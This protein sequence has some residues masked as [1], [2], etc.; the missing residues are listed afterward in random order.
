[1]AKAH[2]FDKDNEKR[3]TEDSP[4]RGEQPEPQE[5]APAEEAQE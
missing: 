4:V 1:M 2:F 5:E 3:I